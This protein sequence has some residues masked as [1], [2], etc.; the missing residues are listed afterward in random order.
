MLRLL[1]VRIN[2][3]PPDQVADEAEKSGGYFRDPL[4]TRDAIEAAVRCVDA[5]K[6]HVGEPMNG[7][8]SGYYW[9]VRAVPEAAAAGPVKSPRRRRRD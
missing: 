4:R 6:R 1:N 7:S 9:Q 2:I 5:G 8:D 3:D